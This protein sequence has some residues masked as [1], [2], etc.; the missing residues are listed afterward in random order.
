MC[1]LGN[2]STDFEVRFWNLPV[3][4]IILYITNENLTQ[5]ECSIISISENLKIGSK[6]RSSVKVILLQLDSKSPFYI[7]VYS[8]YRAYIGIILYTYM[9]TKCTFRNNV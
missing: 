4:Y 7:Y 5:F 3:E 9:Y 6:P 2:E 1:N 8:I